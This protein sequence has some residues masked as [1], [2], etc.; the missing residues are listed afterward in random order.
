MKK[1]LARGCVQFILVVTKT[2]VPLS[3]VLLSHWSPRKALVHDQKVASSGVAAYGQMKALLE[4][5]RA[6]GVV[7]VT[8]GITVG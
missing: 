3:L 4:S 6:S 1:A 8:S 2:T 5:R 7:E